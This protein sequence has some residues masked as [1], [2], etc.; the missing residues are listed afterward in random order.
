MVTCIHREQFFS[1]HSAN[2]DSEF[3]AYRWVLASWIKYLQR[4]Q[5]HRWRV[6]KPTLRLEVGDS[7]AQAVLNHLAHLNQVFISI[8]WVVSPFSLSSMWP[9]LRWRRPPRADYSGIIFS[10]ALIARIECS[11]LKVSLVARIEAP[12]HRQMN[13]TNNCACAVFLVTFTWNAILSERWVLQK[14]R[15]RKLTP[16]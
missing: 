11:W 7:T 6:S 10:A 13:P 3:S 12:I 9:A 1:S 15:I 4:S 2:V 16:H 14:E 5:L 8:S